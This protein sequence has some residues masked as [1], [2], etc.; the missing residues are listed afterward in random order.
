MARVRGRL[1]GALQHLQALLR[2]P[3][4]LHHPPSSDVFGH[5]TTW[6]SHHQVLRKRGIEPV[7]R[8]ET[9]SFPLLDLSFQ[10][11]NASFGAGCSEPGW[12]VGL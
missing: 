4:Y 9:T 11:D 1:H 8:M 10:G 7:A 12:V 2:C 6:K 5:I 3:L